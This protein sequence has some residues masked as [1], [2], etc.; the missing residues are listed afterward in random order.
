[1][2]RHVGQTDRVNVKRIDPAIDIRENAA[3]H[4]I[5]RHRLDQRRTQF[6][7]AMQRVLQKHERL[8]KIADS[9]RA[10]CGRILRLCAAADA[11]QR[12]IHMVEN[13]LNRANLALYAL[14]RV[15]PALH[16]LLQRVQ[17]PHRLCFVAVF[18]SALQCV[19]LVYGRHKRGLLP[20]CCFAFPKPL[21]LGQQEAIGH[22]PT[23]VAEALV[24][25]GNVVRLFADCGH[26][27]QVSNRSHILMQR[28]AELILHL[29]SRAVDQQAKPRK[30]RG[31][32]Q[33]AAIVARAFLGIQRQMLE[34]AIHFLAVHVSALAE[35]ENC[36]HIVRERQRNARL[37]DILVDLLFRK[38]PRAEQQMQEQ[39][40]PIRF[41]GADFAFERIHL[42]RQQV[43]CG[44]NH[45][46]ILRLRAIAE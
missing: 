33:H 34:D 26:Y 3:C 18:H 39:R 8:R 4:R 15:H 24:C 21:A 7:E 43:Q 31:G 36:A 10:Q 29:P 40:P 5:L 12:V 38:T 9:R 17:N 22:R 44:R 35:L 45:R 23:C 16:A 20:L 25:A 11:E 32:I 46:F 14:Q 41:R 28:V 6:K 2:C 19:L 37:L 13:A 30:H 1:M 42:F 27:M